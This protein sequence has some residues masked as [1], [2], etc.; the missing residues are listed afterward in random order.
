M[1]P[2]CVL[3]CAII[4]SWFAT[5]TARARLAPPFGRVLHGGGQEPGCFESYSSYLGA[6]GPSVKMFY[7]GLSG[8][9]STPSGTTP[10]WFNDTL[11]SLESDAGVD[12]AF[13]IPQI[14]LELPLNGAEAL[15]ASGAYDNAI[16]AL[17]NGLRLLARPV[18]LRIGYEFNGM[19]W[20]GYLPKSYIGAY[21]R[22]A[23]AIRGDA[24]LEPNTALVWDGT[25]DSKTDP[26]PYYPGYDVVDWQGINIFSGASGPVANEGSCLW[27][28]LSGNAASGT[29][30]LIGEST[31]RGFNSSDP[32]MWSQWFVPFLKNLNDYP[33]IG[34][35]SY[36]DQDWTTA[37]GGR[38]KDWGDSRVEIAAA[39]GVVGDN[40]KNE[41][42]T[43][44]RW[45][46][47]AN[48]S[49]ILKLLGL[50]SQ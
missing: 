21:R 12:D 13:L 24:M 22:I 48:K 10:Q 39:Q 46:N 20:N 8:L 9:N 7:L 34:L 28:W 49:T 27:Y 41:L 40:W 14:G 2:L 19:E 36:I 17:I 42:K 47:R 26:T 11:T 43:S 30:L 45:V 23:A 1:Y 50:P 31:P 38:W 44:S 32:N 3:F 37:E 33:I 16:T 15:V 35:V 6:L 4:F 18:Y 25:C 5:A 29:P